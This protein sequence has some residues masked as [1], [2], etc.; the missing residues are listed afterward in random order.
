MKHGTIL[1]FVKNN[2]ETI[3]LR[4]VCTYSLSR[5]TYANQFNTQLHDFAF[6]LGY[7]H[8]I[9]F[10][11]SDVKSVSI[12]VFSLNACALTILQENISIDDSF[13]APIRDF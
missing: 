13:N 4:L 2:P 10:V 8:D 6:R 11:H 3:R 1:Q 5:T 7:F 12:E 9:P